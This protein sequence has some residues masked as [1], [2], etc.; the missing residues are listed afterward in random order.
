MTTLTT[1]AVIS[2]EGTLH[3]DLPSGLPP[4]PVEVV[5][6]VQPMPSANGQGPADPLLGT[7]AGIAPDIDVD[8][9]LREMDEQWKRS[10]EA[11]IE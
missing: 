2:P 7:W 8:A 3:L 5:V 10:I 9:T 11:S 6:V 1:R 4:G